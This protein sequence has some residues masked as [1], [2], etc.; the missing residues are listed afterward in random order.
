MLA[1]AMQVILGSKAPPVPNRQRI[2]DYL[3]CPENLA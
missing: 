1:T 2:I 3:G